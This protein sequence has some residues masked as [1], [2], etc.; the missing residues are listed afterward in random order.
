M[1]EMMNAIL[2]GKIKALYIMGENPMLADPD[3]H[4]VEQALKALDFL[5]VQDIFLMLLK[6][7]S[8]R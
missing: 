6:D 2:D 7:L 5:V 1:V 3:I 4:H 8:G